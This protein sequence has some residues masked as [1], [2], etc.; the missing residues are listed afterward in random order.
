MQKIL[1]IGKTPKLLNMKFQ[2]IVC[3]LPCKK[4]LSRTAAGV[5]ACSFSVSVKEEHQIYVKFM[6]Y[7]QIR[8]KRIHSSWENTG[9]MCIAKA[10]YTRS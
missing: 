8:E 9:L 6:Q 3:Q 2:C 7:F 1:L 4:C 5:M 10:R